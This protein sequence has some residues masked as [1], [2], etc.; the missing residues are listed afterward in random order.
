MADRPVRVRIPRWKK[1]VFT[2]VVLAVALFCLEGLMRCCGYGPLPDPAA[3]ADAE[4]GQPEIDE[5]EYY[6]RSDPYLGFRNR[7]NGRY[8]TSYIV[9]NPLSTTDQ[10]G[11]R[12]GY[13]WPGDGQSPLLL[14]CVLPGTLS[15]DD[16]PQWRG[17]TR[18]GVWRESG[19]IEEFDAP[20][21][22]L[23]WSVP[24]SGGY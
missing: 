16:W 15:A 11:Y 8:R 22:K 18:D 14:T 23:R 1:L 24:I 6:A 13:G 10:F 4:T 21:I 3:P 9:G 5:F 17:P 2:A 12:N 20:Q 7:A 19:I